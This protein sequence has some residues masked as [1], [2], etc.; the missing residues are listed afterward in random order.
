[1]SGHLKRATELLAGASSSNGT[2]KTE[3]K[4]SASDATAR[5][6]AGRLAAAQTPAQRTAV[7]WDRVRAAIRDLPE[8]DQAEAWRRVAADVQMIRQKIEGR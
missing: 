7:E 2:P 3:R 1:M 8:Q 4:G 6:W 5:H